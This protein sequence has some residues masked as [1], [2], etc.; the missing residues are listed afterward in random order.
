MLS[1][2][3][4][5]SLLA[6]N[7]YLLF[8]N[9]FWEHSK[10]YFT[11]T[12]LILHI[13][14][15]V[16]SL[17]WLPSQ[18]KYINNFDIHFQCLYHRWGGCICHQFL[19]S[20]TSFNYELASSP[21]LYSFHIWWHFL[22]IVIGY[23]NICPYL[24]PSKCKWKFLQ[25]SAIVLHLVHAITFVLFLWGKQFFRKQV[26]KLHFNIH[27]TWSCQAIKFDEESTVGK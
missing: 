25:L 22:S 3:F 15:L 6:T 9:D 21:L 14:Y 23:K 2:S 24:H 20:S 26:L 7:C 19:N 8:F 4:H 27:S 12:C 11:H 17:D 10:A 18:M 16:K 1:C 13:W 5:C